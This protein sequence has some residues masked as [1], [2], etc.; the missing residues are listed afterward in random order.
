[1]DSKLTYRTTAMLNGATQHFLLRHESGRLHPVGGSL[2][3]CRATNAAA[4]SSLAAVSTRQTG[5]NGRRGSLRSFRDPNRGADVHVVGLLDA[6]PGLCSDRQR[7]RALEPA[8][9]GLAVLKNANPTSL[10]CADAQYIGRMDIHSARSIRAYRMRGPVPRRQRCMR[11]CPAPEIGVQ[12][13]IRQLPPG[14]ISWPGGSESAP[15]TN[16]WSA[17][18]LGSNPETRGLKDRMSTVR[19][20]PGTS[21]TWD[22]YLPGMARTVMNCNQS[23]N[24]RPGAGVVRH[25]R[26]GSGW[27]GPRG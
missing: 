5:M 9:A 6:P 1:M 7:P 8:P 19:A 15:S 10:T 14:V 24:H 12:N 17:R 18:C 27:P 3:W 20:G 4:R 16:L 13:V 2:S 21:V 25:G 23:C 22:A 11:W 26:R